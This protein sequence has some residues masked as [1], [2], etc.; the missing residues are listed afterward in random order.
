MAP[1]SCG[2]HPQRGGARAGQRPGGQRWCKTPA[3]GDAIRGQNALDFVRKGGSPV[4]EAT[5][6]ATEA[7]AQEHPPTA[8]RSTGRAPEAAEALQ[9]L[10]KALFGGTPPVRFEFW[11]GSAS[12]PSVSA[13]TVTVRSADALRY[14][15]WSPGELGLGR[16]YLL[17]DLDFDG[18]A[19]G[20]DPCA[21]RGDAQGPPPG[22]GGARRTPGG[23]PSRRRSSGRR[24]RPASKLDRPDGVTPSRAM[25]E[26]SATTTTW[27]TSSTAWSSGRA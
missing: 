8:A 9:P 18:E 25:P 27:A 14:L 16:A 3:A 1:V 24:P 10:F 7:P 23:P 11:D 22:E 2:H 4:D 20:A 13:G 26:P 17:G 19:L 21:Q 6:S 5:F 15:I 12:G